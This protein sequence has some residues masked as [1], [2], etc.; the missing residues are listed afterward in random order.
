MHG[1]TL[2]WPAWTLAVAMTLGAGT[3]AWGQQ[4]ASPLLPTDPGY[5]LAAES[6]YGAS[7]QAAEP[8]GAT[9]V[10]NK[11]AI[12]DDDL[13]A[14]VADLEAEIQKMKAKEAAAKKKAAG[15]PSVDVGGRIYA[16]Q[17][18]FGQSAASLA[19]LT[20]AQD[21]THF[22][23]AR[24]FVDGDAFNVMQYKI[25]MDFA[26]RSNYTTSTQNPA[27]ATVDHTHG[28]GNVGTTSFK[29]V[30]IAVNDL[31]L[32]GQVKVGHFKEP[33][34]L[35]ELTSS[36][37][38]T[39]MERSLMNVFTPGRN[40]GVMSTNVAASENAT[41]AIG[42]F[43]TLG[44]K[45]PYLADDDLGLTMTARATWLPWYDE[46]TDGRGLLH[47][48]LGYSYRSVSN[49]V[50]RVRQRPEVGVGPRVVDTGNFGN[51][52]DIH[53]FNPEIA[54]MY[55]PFSVQSEFMGASYVRDQGVGDAFFPATYVQ[56]SYFLT[57]EN[58]GYDR[59]DGAFDRVKPFENFFR[60]R[61]ADGNVYTG[62]GAWEL[63]YRYSFLD[64]DHASAAVFGGYASD[65]TF[66]VNWYLNPY[67]RLMFNYIH[68]HVGPAGN[69]LA[70]TFID[71]FSMR[72]QIDF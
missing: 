68:S 66:G 2:R 38:I 42:V 29:D 36:R 49:A 48:G 24:I 60:V 46:A 54:F 62:K 18:F 70:D 67:T 17:V 69:Q 56:V 58:R 40:I 22:R 45:P 39:F 71:V 26:G 37:F 10:S 4:S 5:T 47:L 7:D 51:V 25:Q 23:T 53:L 27:A 28:I 52:G 31:P 9:L 65:H 63:A 32:A 21:T 8:T 3:V 41:F 57:G 50:Q 12:K 35:E 43:R 19:R 20:D 6:N 13:A 30:Y 59:A 34:S 44:D 14:K 11:M 1:R 33:M 64:L 16:D 55:G 15:R 61:A 72:A